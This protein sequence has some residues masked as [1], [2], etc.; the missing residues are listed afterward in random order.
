MATQTKRRKKPV[1]REYAEIIVL[2]VALALFVGS[3]LLVQGSLAAP[4]SGEA[5]AYEFSGASPDAGVT[6]RAPAKSV[7]RAESAPASEGQGWAYEWSGASRD[8]GVILPAEKAGHQSSE[9]HPAADEPERFSSA[10]SH[11]SGLSAK[12]AQAVLGGWFE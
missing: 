11:P 1:L 3:G 4:S 7:H 6:L 10:A 2:A 5:A 8:A 9:G 12:Q